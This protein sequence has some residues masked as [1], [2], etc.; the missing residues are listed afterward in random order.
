MLSY[1]VAVLSEKFLHVSLSFMICNA[2]AI[3]RH[4]VVEIGLMF[5]VGEPVKL[6]RWGRKV[7]PRPPSEQCPLPFSTTV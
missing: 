2:C 1:A 6:E 4:R 7:W 3:N 5:E